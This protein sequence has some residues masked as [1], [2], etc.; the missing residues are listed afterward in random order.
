MRR[1]RLGV[2][3]FVVPLLK[4]GSRPV[5]SAILLAVT[6]YNVFMNKTRNTVILVAGVVVLVAIVAAG[7][8]FIATQSKPAGEIT[9]KVTNITERPNV[10]ENGYYG[11]EVQDKA[12]TTYTINAT[13]NINGPIPPQEQCVGVPQVHEGQQV[14]FH[15]PKSDSSQNAFDICYQTGS[16]NY[17]FK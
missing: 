16:G 1:S 4:E 10:S 15:L 11:I 2:S 7:F 5:C 9:A 12:G 6:C 3:H 13:G 8:K 17:Y 14:T